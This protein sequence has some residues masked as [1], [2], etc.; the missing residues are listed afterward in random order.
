MTRGCISKVITG[1][2]DWFPL[3]SSF[4]TPH[5]PYLLLSMCHRGPTESTESNLAALLMQRLGDAGITHWKCERGT[6]I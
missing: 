4:F 6:Y 3:T 1:A 2:V 5:R